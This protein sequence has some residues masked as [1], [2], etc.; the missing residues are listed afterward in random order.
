MPAL[1][2]PP[3]H[4]DLHCA[5]WLRLK[6]RLSTLGLRCAAAWRAQRRRSEDRRILQEMSER[7]LRDIGLGRCDVP[8]VA[9]VRHE[10]ASR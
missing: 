8:Y 5:P 4:S 6:R 10:S 1:P 9:G 3:L 7:D 2:I